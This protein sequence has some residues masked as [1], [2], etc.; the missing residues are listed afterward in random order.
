MGSS[1]A[2]GALQCEDVDA[3]LLLAEEHPEAA[4]AQA[5]KITR[6]LSGKGAGWTRERRQ[7]VRRED[8]E[9]L[10]AYAERE[11]GGLDA[12]ASPEGPQG[13]P[14]TAGGLRRAGSA[15]A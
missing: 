10:E 3:L 15:V 11:G 1:E 14:G 4:R 2:A 6:R 8:R 7:K 13:G 5:V 9:L 12:R